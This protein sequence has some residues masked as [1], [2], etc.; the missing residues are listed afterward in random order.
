MGTSSTEYS[1]ARDGNSRRAVVLGSNSFTGSWMVKTLLEKGYAV[2]GISRSE[3][4]ELCFLPYRWI[5]SEIQKEFTFCKYDIN[6]DAHRVID[7]ITSFKPSLVFNYSA[8]GMVGPSWTSPWEWYNTNLTSLVK[9]TEGICHRLEDVVFVQASTPEVYGSTGNELIQE[10]EEYS[11][12]TPYAVSKAAFDM[13]L[14]NMGLQYGFRYVL[15]RAANI[16]GPGQQLYRIIPKTILSAE[17]GKQ[18]TLD[19]GGTSTRSFVHVEDVCVASFA[20]A[21]NGRAGSIW[22]IATEELVSIRS[23]VE[24]ICRYVEVPFDSIVKVGPERRGKDMSY[25][26]SSDKI[27]EQ[28]GWTPKI[29]LRTG[30]KQTV[31]WVNENKKIMQEMKWDYEHRE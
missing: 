11:P 30:I 2:L 3:E 21:L 5:S 1:S 8:Q 18:L 23:L 31:I 16:Y 29:D 20:A 10:N 22:H 7:K 27:R 4:K 6:K 14:K 17:T 13:H 25:S 12:S 9:I 15:T 26:M 28:L 24:T 19:G